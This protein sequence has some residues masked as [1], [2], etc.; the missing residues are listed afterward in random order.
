MSEVGAVFDPAGIHS[1]G[2]EAPVAFIQP[3]VT[4]GDI[5]DKFA[6]AIFIVS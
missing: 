2:K 3:P 5:T 6:G 1:D 4:A